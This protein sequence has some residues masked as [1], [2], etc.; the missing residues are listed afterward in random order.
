MKYIDI[1]LI[2]EKNIPQW[3]KSRSIEIKRIMNLNRGRPANVTRVEMDVHTG[4]HIDAPKH[5]IKNGRSI[6]KINLNELIG[7][8]YLYNTGNKD[9]INIDFLKGLDI[10]RGIDKILLKTKNSKLWKDKKF[11]KN[12]VALTPEAAKWVV[13]KKIK[14]VGIDY[15]SIQKFNEKDNKTH[16]ILLKNGVVIIEGLNL[17]SVKQGMYEL[18]VLPIKIK[19]SD[20]APARA[21]LKIL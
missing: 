2:I 11:H 16:K 6:D 1:S 14:L 5:F 15:L 13:K 20:G 19:D 17:N 3:P 21:I 9:E 8:C 18:I 7:R 10:P 12:F 4:T